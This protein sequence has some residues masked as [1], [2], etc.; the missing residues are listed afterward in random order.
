MDIRKSKTTPREHYDGK[1]R[2][3][4]WYRDNQV[5]FITAR[6]QTKLHLFA[7]DE[8]KQIFWIKFDQYTKQFDFTPWVTS[9][10]INHYHTLGYLR[11]GDNLP[12]MMQKL[13]GSVAKLVNDTL[14]AR[15]VP[16]WTD[17]GK[18]N[19]FDGCIRDEIQARRAYRYVHTQ[20]RRHFICDD[21][22]DYPHTK[23]NVEIE[24]AVKRAR[25]LNAFLSG[26][27][28]ARY[29]RRKPDRS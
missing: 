21:P 3:E 22:V 26:V 19:Y 18:Q 5:Y 10:L 4:H 14:D 28:Y 27:P 12:K 17:S 9:L 11:A 15:I 2:F 23:V 24:N 1:H 16:F 7:S 13:H 25:E 6:C 20:C 29:D 8:A